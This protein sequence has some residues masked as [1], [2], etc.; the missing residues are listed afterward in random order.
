MKKIIFLLLFSISF[1]K[2]DGYYMGKC[3]HSIESIDSTNTFT[4]NFSGNWTPLQTS[5][6][7]V[8]KDILPTLGLFEYDP[9]YAI[10]KSKTSTDTTIRNET[11]FKY[12]LNEKDYNLS[13][14]IYGILL[15]SLIAFGL[16]KAF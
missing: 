2:A 5:N 9:L 14:A 16:I 15:S 13:M 12:G 10:C 7:T 3:V 6:T 11:I 8:F 1:S 4:V